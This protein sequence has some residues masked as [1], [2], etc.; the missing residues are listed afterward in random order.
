MNRLK[1]TINIK[2]RIVWIN[3]WVEIERD[4]GTNKIWREKTSKINPGTGE[5]SEA[6]SISSR[7]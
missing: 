2:F 7:R 1:I 3:G 4:T 6:E 5:N